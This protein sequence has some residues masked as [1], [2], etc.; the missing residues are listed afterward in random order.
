MTERNLWAIRG[1]EHWTVVDDIEVMLT[2]AEVHA[3]AAAVRT[4]HPG[5]DMVLVAWVAPWRAGEPGVRA[6]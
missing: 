5:T 1:P 2:D 3:F 4:V 6:L